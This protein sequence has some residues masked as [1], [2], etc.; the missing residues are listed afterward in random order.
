MRLAYIELEKVIR[1]IAH[2][3][4]PTL[5]HLPF[6]T[7]KHRLISREVVHKKLL[8]DLAKLTPIN[9]FLIEKSLNTTF[10][11][12]DIYPS[13]SIWERLVYTLLKINK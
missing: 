7:I 11:D 5:E 2:S 12:S 3:A 13:W 9:R 10:L 1:D 8:L 4:N 6:L